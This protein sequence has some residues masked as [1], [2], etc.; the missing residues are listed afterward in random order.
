MRHWLR[1]A[2]WLYPAAWRAR[3]GRE[4]DALLGDLDP[5]WRDLW[6]ILRGAIT[7]QLSTPVTY[8]KLGA[9]TAVAG[10]LI[11]GGVSFA[12]PER[13]VSSAVMRV[14]P[15]VPAAADPAQ[16]QMVGSERLSFLQQDV[17]SRTSLAEIIQRP[18][19][20]LYPADRHRYPLEDVIQNMRQRDIL[21][22]TVDSKL[23]FQGSA[24]AFQ[25]S[26]VYP[27]RAKAQNVVR[28]LIT[29][30]ADTNV[31]ASMGTTDQPVAAVPMPVNLEVID[32]ASLPEKAVEPDRFGIAV[33]GLGAGFGLGL[34]IASLRRR[35]L[36]WTLWVAGSAILGFVAF[37]AIAIAAEMSI[38]TEA[39]YDIVLFAAF[40]AATT[41]SIAAY[42]L[43]DREAW[44]PVPYLRSALAAAVCAAILTGLASFAV[45]EHYVSTAIVRVFQRNS[46]GAPGPDITGAVT[47]RLHRTQF[48]MLS[49]NSLAEMIQRPSLNLYHGERQ[50]RPMED[51]IQDMRR[52][53]RFQVVN[54]T[55]IAY[56]ISFEYPDRFKAQAV[57]REMV[58]K[59][60][61]TNVTQ[62]RNANRVPGAPGSIVVE[63]LD[64]A[65]DPVKPV[66]PDRLQFAATGFAAGLPLGLLIAFLRRRPPGQASAML[67][68]ATATG[69]AG[70]V[71]AGAISFAIPSRYVSTA[72]LRLRAPEGREAPD[73]FASQQIQQRMME[74]LSRVSLAELIQ[75]PEL[76]L[77]HSERARQPMEAIVTAMRDRDLRIESLDVGPPAGTTTAFS[78]AFEY[79]DPMKAHA[80]VQTLVDKFVEGGIAPTNLEVL[81]PPSIPQAPAFPERLWIVG[82]G[83]L[84]GVALGSL[85]DLLRRRQPF[86][87]TQ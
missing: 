1:L 35:P 19:L 79:S 26:F 71:V 80:V 72:V 68:F 24:S 77:Y 66:S 82:I 21:I 44:R 57:V 52:D 49:R 48:E 33:I 10:A 69:V 15:Q 46:F 11:A 27:D 54:P 4:F 25:I 67:R 14:M 59:L 63:V 29:K 39:G 45:P 12:L 47:E 58:T 36:R 28:A 85:A 5:R 34:L 64:P 20:D 83:L 73:R 8:F 3:Y 60:I 30:F 70:A 62:E 87:V 37:F 7:M 81:D 38:A 43:R 23:P 16:Y 74:V 86:P 42:V 55:R 6:D 18:E 84:I 2:I 53:L 13:Y 65:S 32:P 76:N 78:I 75:R 51:I 56:T 41:A 61:E 50:R 9:A 17:L 31:R 40:G 22:M